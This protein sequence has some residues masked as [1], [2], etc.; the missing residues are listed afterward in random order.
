M[1]K[2][3]FE[4]IRKKG[5]LIYEYM[6]GSHSYG[7]NTPESDVDTGGVYLAPAEQLLGL[8]LDYQDQVESETHDDVWF[9]M[10]KFMRLL[11]S[12][13]PTVLESL[14]IP[15]DCILY[16]HPI[17]TEIKK[18]RDKF[19]TKKCFDSFG[20]YAISQIRKARGLNKKIVNPVTERKGPLD[21]A[22][23][24][25]RQGSTKIENW[26]EHRGLYQKYCGLVNI[27]NM[28]MTMG[29]YY[30]WGNHF[31]NEKVSLFNLLDGYNLF[32]ED[33]TIPLIKE[34]KRFVSK[35]DEAYNVS[36]ISLA[37]EYEIELLA[38]DHDIYFT[39]LG[40]MVRFICDFYKVSVDDGTFEKWFKE[41]KPIG[42]KGMVG[43]DNLSN[44]L[45]L[46]SVSK[47]EE[48]ICKMYYNKDGYSQHCR[49]YKE[50]KEWE[51][52]RNPVRYKSNLNKNYDAKN[53]LHSFRLLQM[54]IEIAKGEGF[55]SDR[56]G[57]D[58]EFLLDVKN[59]K[60]EY[61][62]IIDM[63]DKKKCEMDEAIAESNIPDDIDVEFV[64][65]LLIDIRKKQL[66]L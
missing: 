16:E 46:S 35:I 42:Y 45:R 12:S 31:L 40:N 8:G 18:H 29:V 20:G 36:D 3:T 22:Y 30:D 33:G 23:T 4:S 52:K 53:M 49:E 5:L 51:E 11:L 38:I 55:H 28:D 60:Y 57:R 17:M 61:E 9:E 44:E 7:L 24:F 66:K 6:R 15:D 50:Y 21:F 25:F 65:Q 10:N 48:P 39:Q 41:Q 34:R 26:L 59:H 1:K 64:N 56:R 54:C 27:P 2:E 63:L 19:I 13:N 58:R 47:G 62:E 43:E 14:F 37:H 32:E